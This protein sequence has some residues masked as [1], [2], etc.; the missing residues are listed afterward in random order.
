[1]K[2]FF[3]EKDLP[4]LLEYFKFN[5][6]KFNRT[7]YVY[8]LALGLICLILALKVQHIYGVLIPVFMIIGYKTPYYNVKRMKSSE[9]LVK[10][11]MFPSL[12]RHFISLTETEG[13]VYKTLEKC[14]TYAKTPLKEKLGVLL[15][16][17]GRT[18]EENQQAFMEFADFIGSY[19][20]IMIMSMIY[21]FE[22]EGIQK[23]GLVELEN[24]LSQLQ[25]NKIEEMINKKSSKMLSFATPVLIYSMAF[26]M[27]FGI[28]T[29]F[30]YFSTVL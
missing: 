30:Q 29:M 28:M 12:I 8:A 27:L 16:K 10:Q 19:E 15:S 3:I 26:V 2:E 20:A 1:M 18:E 22:R 9:D 17:L 7:R 14:Q 25:E 11:L 6:R 23:E 5:N 4:Y 13:N 24:V 21:E